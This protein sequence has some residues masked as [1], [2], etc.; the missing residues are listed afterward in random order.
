MSTARA[1]KIGD[2]VRWNSEAGCVKGTIIA[3][4]SRDV[5]W[6]GYCHH[7][8]RDDPQYEIQGDKTGHIALHKSGALTLDDD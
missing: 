2:H 1:F 8:T 6:K 5:D 7:A 3:V 4:H